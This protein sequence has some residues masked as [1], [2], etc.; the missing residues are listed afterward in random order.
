MISIKPAGQLSECGKN[1]N[2]AIFCDTINIIN[3]KFCMMIVLI[4]LYPFIPL[5]ATFI[6]F[7]VHSNVKTVLTKNGKFLSN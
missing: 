6:A 1:L 3:V 5:S 2:I 4:E 7:E